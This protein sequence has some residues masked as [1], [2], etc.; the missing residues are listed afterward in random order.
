MANCQ[1]CNSERIW[2]TTLKV[3]D[4]FNLRFEDGDSFRG[5]VPAGVGIDGDDSGGKY[6]GDYVEFS[7]CADCLQIQGEGNLQ[8]PETGDV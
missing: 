2:S 3:T 8:R 1:Q 5:Y 4:G 7:Y 6:G